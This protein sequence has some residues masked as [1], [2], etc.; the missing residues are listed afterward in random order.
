LPDKKEAAQ[1]AWRKIVDMNTLQRDVKRG[2]FTTEQGFGLLDAILRFLEE[3]HCDPASRYP[4]TIFHG[5]PPPMALQKSAYTSFLIA[6]QGMEKKTPVMTMKN[7]G[8][9]YEH[10]RFV[11]GK[12]QQFIEEHR[13]AHGKLL[14]WSLQTATGLRTMA[15]NCAVHHDADGSALAWLCALPR[16]GATLTRQYAHALVHLVK[17]GPRATFPGI[18]RMHTRLFLGLYNELQSLVD[19]RITMLFLHHAA[20]EHTALGMLAMEME[21]GARPPLDILGFSLVWK[22]RVEEHFRIDNALRQLLLA[23]LCAHMVARVE[24][25]LLLETLP[26]H[27]DNNNNMYEP[28]GIPLPSATIF[29]QTQQLKQQNPWSSALI[30]QQSSAIIRRGNTQPL[31]VLCFRMKTFMAT[32]CHVARCSY[33]MHSAM[34]HSIWNTME[35]KH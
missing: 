10:M 30:M 3:F 21:A 1:T 14:F 2:S 27:N 29:H 17:E 20:E 32:L 18:L 19:L 16:A 15:R 24:Q 23:R 4:R 26:L 33:G 25:V 22:Q 28:F 11:H 5:M 35:H 12:V 31:R 8:S 9:L 34:L 7:D 13:D 6:Q